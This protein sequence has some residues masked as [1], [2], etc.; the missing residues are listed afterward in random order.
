[1]IK[2]LLDENDTDRLLRVLY[3]GTRPARV[4]TLV[5]LCGATADL[6]ESPKAWNG[7]QVL[8]HARCPICLDATR[9]RTIQALFPNRARNRFLLQLEELQIGEPL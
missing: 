9:A 6:R 5:C 1:M 4:H 8:P 3:N 2:I 7:W